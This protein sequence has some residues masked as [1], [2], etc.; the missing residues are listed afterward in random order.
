MNN[1]KKLSLDEI[2][3]V[4]YEYLAKLGVAAGARKLEFSESYISRILSGEVVPS[5]LKMIE[6]LKKMGYGND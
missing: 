3:K 6:Y 5:H 4:F 1:I 2:E